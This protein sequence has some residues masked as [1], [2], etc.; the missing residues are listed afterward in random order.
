MSIRV[1]WGAERLHLPLPPPETTLGD[2]R[3]AIS[4]HIHLPPASFK[5][6]HSGAVM[7]GDTFPL[8]AY[9]IR[10]GSTI[11]VVG[12]ASP[13][14]GRKSSGS[15]SSK[16]ASSSAVARPS[17]QGLI[18]VITNEM[19]QVRKVLLPGVQSFQSNVASTKVPA[20]QDTTLKQEHTRLGELLLQ[21]LL[22]LDA[23]TPQ[24]EWV[25]ARSARKTAVKEVQNLLSQLDGA[26]KGE[27]A[28][29]PTPSNEVPGF[30]PEVSYNEDLVFRGLFTVGVTVIDP[31]SLVA[32]PVVSKREVTNGHHKQSP[33]QGLTPRSTIHGTKSLGRSR[34]DPLEKAVHMEDMRTL[35][36]NWRNK[37]KSFGSS[38]QPVTRHMDLLSGQS[39]PGTLQFGQHPSNGTR[40]IPQMSS[41]S[42]SSSAPP[43]AVTS[44]SLSLPVAHLQCATA[45]QSLTT[46]F[47]F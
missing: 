46:T 27:Q 47:I 16:P 15:S 18:D 5:L 43:V 42:S 34:L 9:S 39:S 23:L 10:N 7:K 13:I 20:A 28:T 26:W 45:C 33:D 25:E 35:A 24:S 3:K 1:K 40:Q 30:P 17:E 37:R 19:A 21:S 4:E 2:L 44:L 8:G 6:I 12:S 14:P 29:L 38:Q 31:Q 41:S 22:R 36:V 32:S 11:Q